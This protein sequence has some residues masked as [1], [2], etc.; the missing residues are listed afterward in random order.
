[1][2]GHDIPRGR[3]FDFGKAADDSSF[4]ASDD[5]EVPDEPVPDLAIPGAMLPV[6]ALLIIGIIFYGIKKMV[7]YEPGKEGQRRAVRGQS[8]HGAHQRV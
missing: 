7:D 8:P 2:A 3:Q 4:N 5:M 6:I 1:M